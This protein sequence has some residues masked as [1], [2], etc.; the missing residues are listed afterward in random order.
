M[1]NLIKDRNGKISSKR[2]AGLS[3]FVIGLGMAVTTGF[4]WYNVDT[5]LIL[6]ILGA[7]STVLGLGTFEKK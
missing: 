5:F 3:C 2:I 6:T 7:G 4:G 1:K